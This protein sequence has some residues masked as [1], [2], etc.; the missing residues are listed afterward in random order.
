MERNTKATSTK[1]GSISG[2][3]L[4]VR[5]ARPTE[6]SMNMDIEKAGVRIFFQ[7]EKGSKDRSISTTSKEEEF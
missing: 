1:E 6:E 7:T 5:L 2:V 3:H 4:S